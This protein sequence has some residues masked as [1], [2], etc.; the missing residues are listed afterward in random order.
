[1]PI[2]SVT[3]VNRYIKTLL[4]G[5]PAL[6]RLMVRGELS[7]FKV[8]ASGHAYFTLKDAAS[9][10]KC[11]MFR[12]RAKYLRFRPENGQSVVASGGIAVYE[13]DGVYQLYVDSLAPEGKG[14][15]A[16]ALRQLKERLAKEGL[17]DPARKQPLPRFPRTIGI[18][19]SRS[20]AVL[21]DIHHVGKRRDPRVQLVLAPVNVQGAGAAQEIAAAIRLFNERYP[22]DLLI[23]GRGGGSMED[24]WAF[25]EE[26]VVRAISAS[27]IPVISAVGHETDT[28]LSDLAADLRAATPSQAA[29][30]AIPDTAALLR[31]IQGLALR[32]KSAAAR[33]IEEKRSALRHLLDQPCLRAPDQLLA[34]RQQQLDTLE[35][36]L[37]RAREAQL[38]KKQQALAAAASRL[39]LLSPIHT[40]ARGYALATKDGQPVTRA[41]TLAPGDHLTIRFSDGTIETK[42]LSAGK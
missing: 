6:R 19:T 16:E 36:R 33:T 22:V 25:N 27:R 11:V 14:A 34:A 30:L 17:F 40:L 24:L 3:N 39:E 2:R 31:D 18:V 23:V 41:K 13:R 7:N 42:V 29:E 35:D 15:L 9:Q 5:E 12:S 10:L 38:E 20:G 28:T 21:H 1:M 26:P 37:A 8:Y 4:E 32:L